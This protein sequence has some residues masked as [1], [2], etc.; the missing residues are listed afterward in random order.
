MFDWLFRKRTIQQSKPKPAKPDAGQLFKLSN[1]FITIHSIG[2]H[3]LVTRSPAKTWVLSWKDS[4]P[5]G[6][7]GGCRDSGE[8][9]YV[10]VDVESNVVRVDAR[11]PRPNNGSVADNG[12]FCLEDWHFGSTLSATFH[13]FSAQGTPIITK[14]LSANILDSGIS[15]SGRLAFCTT[16]NSPTEDTHKL[17]LFDLK[18]GRQLFAVTP[19]RACERFE[20]D[21]SAQQLVAKVAGGGEYRYGTDG[22]LVDEG[23]GDVALLGSTSYSEVI[24]TA[25]SMLKGKPGFAE[26]ESILAALIRA[27]G[28]GAGDNPAWKPTALKVQGLAHEALG[29]AREAIG[30]YKEALRLNPKIGV[31]RR[32]DA[33]TRRQL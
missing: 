18:E 3:G 11:M 19:A 4:T 15:R 14:E 32:L 2:Y 20:F 26:L 24:L 21:E 1:R 10:L 9:R 5:D 27:R 13:V 29:Q 17:F 6:T 7:R 28:L 23:A 22:D 8:G 16:A 25:E 30:C 33:L 12:T 31:K